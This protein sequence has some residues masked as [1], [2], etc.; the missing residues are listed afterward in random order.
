MLALSSYERSFGMR[1]R[2]RG[3]PLMSLSG[4][5][6]SENCEECGDDQVGKWGVILWRHEA[7]LRRSSAMLSELRQWGKGRRAC[8][9]AEAMSSSS[10]MI[11]SGLRSTHRG[12]GAPIWPETVHIPFSSISMRISC[13]E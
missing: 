7:V 11:G 3:R 13:V 6:T 1:M 12:E 9:I 10:R 2:F 5:K 4:P 8:S